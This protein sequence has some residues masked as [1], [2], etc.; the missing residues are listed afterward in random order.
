[1][2]VIPFENCSESTIEGGSQK[3]GYC[4][5]QHIYVQSRENRSGKGWRGHCG[6]K[7]SVGINQGTHEGLPE[8]SRCATHLVSNDQSPLT[9]ALDFENLHNGAIT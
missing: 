4:T 5:Y 7:G 1:M 9:R 3:K 8:E 6:E 2:M